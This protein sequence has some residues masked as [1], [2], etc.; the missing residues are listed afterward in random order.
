MPITVGRLPRQVILSS[1]TLDYLITSG[2]L[3]HY[4]LLSLL[5]WN[6]CVRCRPYHQRI[7]RP[8]AK[9]SLVPFETFW[10]IAQSYH[11]QT[12]ANLFA[13]PQ[14]LL[15]L[16]SARFYT[17]F[18]RVKLLIASPI[19]YGSDSPQDLFNLQNVTSVSC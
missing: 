3:S 1:V 4:I 9:P 16:A 2:I 14:M 15:M 12:L 17:S 10:L 6:A 7:G 8:T 11:T 13:S 19:A 5:L 18:G